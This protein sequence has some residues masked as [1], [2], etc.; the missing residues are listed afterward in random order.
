MELKGF[1]LWRLADG[2]I[3]ERWVFEIS[4][5]IDFYVALSD[6]SSFG[7]LD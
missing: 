4:I 3:A 6:L 2:K 1:V 7:R 5:Q